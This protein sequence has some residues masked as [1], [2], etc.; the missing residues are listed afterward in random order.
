MNCKSSRVSRYLL[1]GVAACA[2]VLTAVMR[3]GPSVAG[4]PWRQMATSLRTQG[5]W[6]MLGSVS[7]RTALSLLTYDLQYLPALLYIFF[8]SPPKLVRHR[9]RGRTNGCCGKSA[10][11]CD[12]APAIQNSPLP[13]GDETRPFLPKA[14]LLSPDG[15][16]AA[17]VMSG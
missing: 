3:D 14:S 6:A 8:S 17:N 15:S 11:D 5:L 9:P 12:L 7:C 4:T 13:L 1:R 2:C 16:R 10:W